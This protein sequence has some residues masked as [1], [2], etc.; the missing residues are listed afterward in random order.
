MHV[1]YAVQA[2]RSTISSVEE[3]VFNDYQV[4]GWISKFN[5]KHSYTQAWYLDQ[6]VYKV[7]SFL[8]EMQVCEENIRTEMQSV[9]FND[10]IAEF[11]Y[12]YVTPTLK[13]LE[14]LSKRIDVLSE[15]RDF[16]NRPFAIEEF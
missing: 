9:F 5:E 6:V 2:L 16:P 15:L 14:E 1:F 3:Q 11:V 10:T 8:R 4:R 13:R 7:K 12:V